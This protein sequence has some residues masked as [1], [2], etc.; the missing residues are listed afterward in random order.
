MA[1]R[2]YRAE[3]ANY[4]RGTFKDFF[5][6]KNA[7]EWVKK[8]IEGND[9]RDAMTAD[10]TDRRLDKTYRVRNWYPIAN[11]VVM[12]SYTSI[13]LPLEKPKDNYDF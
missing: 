10:I 1:I 5:F 2:R 13:S 6:L 7:K 11:I 4:A 8:N 12:G 3:L 9:W